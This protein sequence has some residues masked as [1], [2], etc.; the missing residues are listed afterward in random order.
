MQLRKNKN[1]VALMRTK[2][3]RID[4]V[5]KVGGNSASTKVAT[6]SRFDVELPP[7]LIALL[8]LDEIELVTR[9]VL[10]PAR[11]MAEERAAAELA[12]LTDPNPCL[13]RA[14]DALEEALRHT[15]QARRLAGVELVERVVERSVKVAL[16]SALNGADSCSATADVLFLIARVMTLITRQISSPSLPSAREVTMENA[17][18]RAWAEFSRESV[19]LRT[20]MQKKKYVKIRTPKDKKDNAVQADTPE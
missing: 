8:T 14:L 16:L 13:A 6:I 12:K 11:V 17:I 7:E 2:Y 19:E 9:E 5:T 4:P 20:V 10:E 3:R 18:S 1:T 15:E